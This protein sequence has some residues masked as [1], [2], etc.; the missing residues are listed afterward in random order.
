[1]DA[2]EDEVRR[3]AEHLERRHSGRSTPA[4]SLKVSPPAGEGGDGGT[5]KRRPNASTRHLGEAE[6]QPYSAGALLPSTVLYSASHKPS[7]IGG[8]NP[9]GAANSTNTI[10]LHGAQRE[11]ETPALVPAA[12]RVARPIRQPNTLPRSQPAA[13]MDPAVAT[14][15]DG[16][17]EH[18]SVT[19][20]IPANRWNTMSPD[21]AMSPSSPVNPSSPGILNPAAGIIKSYSANRPQKPRTVTVTSTATSSGTLERPAKEEQEQPRH[22]PAAATPSEGLQREGP[23]LL[24]RAKLFERGEAS[25]SGTLKRGLKKNECGEIPTARE[26]ASRAVKTS[27]EPGSRETPSAATGNVHGVSRS[28]YESPPSEE[29][30]TRETRVVPIPADGTM[31]TGS[32][33]PREGPREGPRDGVLESIIT[34]RHRDAAGPPGVLGDKP[35]LHPAIRELLGSAIKLTPGMEPIRVPI[36]QEPGME[37]IR[38]PISQGLGMEPVRAPVSQGLGMEP[39]RAPV[40]QGLGMEPIRAPV[41]QGLGMEPI[42]APVSQG[43]ASDEAIPTP[44]TL[45]SAVKLTDVHLFGMSVERNTKTSPIITGRSDTTSWKSTHMQVETSSSDL[46]E[47]VGVSAISTTNLQVG[48]ETTPTAPAITAPI[49]PVQEG[50]ATTPTA[51]V[52][53]LPNADL[54]ESVL[55]ACEPS[56]TQRLAECNHHMF[57]LVLPVSPAQP[58]NPKET[59]TR[60]E[61]E[62]KEELTRLRQKVEREAQRM[63]ELCEV[64]VREAGLRLQKV[65]LEEELKLQ[66]EEKEAGLKRQ[67]NLEAELKLQKEIEAGLRLQLDRKEAELRQQCVRGLEDV[68]RLQREQDISEKRWKELSDQE[69]KKHEERA[70]TAREAMEQEM[71]DREEQ[72]KKL[73]K[74]NNRLEREKWELLRR[75]R[76]AAERMLGIRVQLEMKEG[77]LKSTQAELT[78]T[79]DELSSVKSSNTGLRTLLAELRASKAGVDEEVQVNMGGPL[80][81]NRSIEMALNQGGMMGGGPEGRDGLDVRDLSSQEVTSSSKS[82]ASPRHASASSHVTSPG[83][84]VSH[85]TSPSPRMGHVTSPGQSVGGHVTSPDQSLGG[86]A[87]AFSQSIGQDSLEQ[88][89]GVDRS[90]DLHVS[91]TTLDDSWCER[92][93]SITSVGSS[94]IDSREST[95]VAERHNPKKKKLGLLERFDKLRKSKRGSVGKWWCWW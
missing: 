26:T 32:T 63:E 61:R 34:L 90:P 58:P 52:L 73:S 50:V 66:R 7:D 84:G 79:L 57:P 87:V 38:A 68:E 60:A 16:T 10:T 71:R 18:R 20:T 67:E 1:M 17:I 3:C 14:D 54:Q 49:A 89:S 2:M 13:S 35:T 25:P 21:R 37:P 23:S 81:R 11:E 41:S 74:D 82:A 30:R 29:E 51:H 75:A 64:E 42:R 45:E 91:S 92:E 33:G 12:K 47:G 8:R 77:L 22:V 78:H 86:H 80:Q 36:S 70:K 5:R 39:V 88:D 65:A 62:L 76:D 83:H 24:E 95:P 31:T 69:L 56:L 94:F 9:E 93:P 43:P 27:P 28:G 53:I 48:V 46:Q 4:K 72:I 44:T 59:E 55:S 85:V 40:S 6:G 15:D 19:V